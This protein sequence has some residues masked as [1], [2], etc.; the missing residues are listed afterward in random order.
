MASEVSYSIPVHGVSSPHGGCQ[1]SSRSNGRSVPDANLSF[2]SETPAMERLKLLVGPSAE[3]GLGERRY[4]F[5]RRGS[6]WDAPPSVV[7]AARGPRRP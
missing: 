4:R 5:R 2:E 7:P 1:L 6:P 3:E